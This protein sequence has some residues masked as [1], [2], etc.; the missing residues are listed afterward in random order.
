MISDE[1]NVLKTGEAMTD[2]Q[3]KLMVMQNFKLYKQWTQESQ[4]LK[5]SLEKQ[6]KMLVEFTKKINQ[7]EQLEGLVR[8]K[9]RDSI[10]RASKVLSEDIREKIGSSATTSVDKTAKELKAV[11][12]DASHSL[13]AYKSEV[14]KSQ[15]WMFLV[16]VGTAIAASLLIF[17]F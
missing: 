5:E 11:V 7:F 1:E 16:T 4:S 9:I 8:D 2:D 17:H 12:S 6:E 3:V 15:I 14:H 10:V 13:G